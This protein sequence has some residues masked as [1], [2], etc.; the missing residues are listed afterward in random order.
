MHLRAYQ[1]YAPIR[2]RMIRPLQLQK[3]RKDKMTI[4]TKNP[5]NEQD[6]KKKKEET[7]CL[8]VLIEIW[9]KK[10]MQTQN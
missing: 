4:I 8:D 1:N 3:I 9:E 7:E 10:I 6:L 2:Q 5:D